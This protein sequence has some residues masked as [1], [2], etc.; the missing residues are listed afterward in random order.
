MARAL[1]IFG[2]LWVVL[3][4]LLPRSVL[5]EASGVSDAGA[6]EAVRL[7]ATLHKV[8]AVLLG[9]SAFAVGWLVKR[10][11]PAPPAPALDF[12]TTRD[13]LAL[14]GVLL[15]ALALRLVGLDSGLWYDEIV[16]LVSFVR[17]P[18]EQLALTYTSL[19]NHMLFSLAARASVLLFSESNW[20]LRL[21]AVLFGVASIAATWWLAIQVLTR[22][23][24]LLVAALMSVS[25]HHVWFSQNARGYTGLLFFSIVATTLFLEGMRRRG[26][27]LWVAYAVVFAL[28]MYVHLSAV[29]TFLAH[30]LVYATLFAVRRVPALRARLVKQDNLPGAGEWWPLLGFAFGSVLILQLNGILFPQMIQVY[31]T[32]MAVQTKGGITEWKNPLWTALEILR[33]LAL[34]PVMAVG[35]PVAGT[36]MAVGFLRFLKDNPLLAT[37][38]V[39]HVP[40]TATILIAIEFHIWPRYFLVDMG[41]FLIILVY[42]AFLVAGWLA[43]KL[44]LAA[45]GLGPERAGT[46]A[47]GLMILVSLATVPRNYQL[48]KQ[49][50]EGAIAFVEQARAPR[51]RIVTVGIIEDPLEDLYDKSWPSV[52]TAED[53]ARVRA[54]AER[55]WLLATFPAQLRSHHPD[56]LEA[57]ERDFEL[58]KAF[59]G[60]LS[61][62]EVLVYRSVKPT[63]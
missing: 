32:K 21:P 26:R 48:P 27:L 35:I 51:D 44:G 47:V 1:Q 9:L 36:L 59:P 52:E 2:A 23:Q 4:L 38:L 50:Y 54:D 7:G 8:F 19:N 18:F 34:N 53:L 46:V 45:R 28:A 31:E 62:G 20:A 14:G 49:D 15:L 63:P 11:R 56:V 39:V 30:T 12:G 10:A 60:T 5:V 58:A 16:T 57:I 61:G 3:G 40:L 24:A 33:V 55:T 6:L 41:F 43:D 22:R 37:L 25:Y 13:R 42:G 29:F 17:L